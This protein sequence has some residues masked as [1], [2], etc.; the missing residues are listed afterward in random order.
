[1]SISNEVR[2]TEMRNMTSEKAAAIIKRN[3]KAIK[4]AGPMSITTLTDYVDLTVEEIHEALTHLSATDAEFQVY[5]ES[6]QKTLTEE[7]RANALWLG[8]QWRHLIEWI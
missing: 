1:M 2:E 5:P 8:N 6:N 4:V 7:D 3:Y